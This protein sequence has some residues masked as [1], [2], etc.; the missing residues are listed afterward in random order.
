VTYSWAQIVEAVRLMQADQGVLFQ[1]MRDI[2]VRYEGEWVMPMIDIANEPKM[3]QLTPAL[4]GEAIDQIALRAASTTPTVFSP[5][6]E[7][8]KDK[9]KRSREYGSIR[10]NIINAT[11]DA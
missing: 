9:G 11:Y 5:P 2:L 3:P 8:N 1:R 7:Y 4:I 10:A 6:I